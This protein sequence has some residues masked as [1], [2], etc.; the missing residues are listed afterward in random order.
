MTSRDRMVLIVLSAL[1]VL[2]AAWLLL[3]SPERKQAVKL[4]SQVTQASTQLATAEGQVASARSAQSRYAAAYASLVSL[5]KAVPPGREVPS[6]VYQLA[7]ASNQKH[8]DFSSI[9]SGAASGS[10]STSS[11]SSSAAATPAAAIAGFTQMPFTFVFTGTFTDLYHLFQQL[12]R[13]TVRTA[14]GGLQVSGRLLTIQSA[15]LAPG[16]ESGSRK[17]GAEQLTG[18]ITATAYVLPATQG[19]TGGATSTSPSA[20]SST[21]VA[22]STPATSSPTAPAIAR[23]TP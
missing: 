2:A 6:L 11:A 23:V 7:Q 19:L 3:V 16:A 20:G 18:T 8:V 13:F 17:G 4:Q 15:T 1:A 9:V 21:S 12:N 14:S 5:G 22:S 10:G